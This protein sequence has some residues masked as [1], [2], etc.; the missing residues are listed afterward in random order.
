[1]SLLDYDDNDCRRKQRENLKGLT[2]LVEYGLKKKL[3]PLVWRLPESVGALVGSTP[4]LA[5]DVQPREAFEAWVAALDAM[6]RVTPRN[7]GFHGEGPT[8]SD[9]TRSDG[10][11]RMIAAFQLPLVKEGTWPR[12]EF[13]ILAEWYEHEDDADEGVQVSA[14]ASERA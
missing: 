5:G 8:R 13:V 14:P 6:P 12:C 2:A 9:R 1:M 11:T 4:Y 10:Q 7:L 3:P